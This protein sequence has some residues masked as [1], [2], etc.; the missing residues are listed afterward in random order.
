LGEGLYKP[1]QNGSEVIPDLILSFN[2]VLSLLLGLRTN[3]ANDRFG[4]AGNCGVFSHTVRNLARGIWIIIEEREPN[5]REEKKS[6]TTTSSCFTVAMKP[7]AA[8]L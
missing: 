5:D 3:S 7:S 8:S 2:I 4:K 6:S 1:A